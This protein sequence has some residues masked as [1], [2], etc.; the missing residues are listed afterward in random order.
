MAARRGATTVLTLTSW[1]NGDPNGLEHGYSEFIYE[2]G[3]AGVIDPQLRTGGVDRPVTS[4]EF[5]RSLRTD[6]VFGQ[7]DDGNDFLVSIGSYPDGGHT[8][9]PG[10]IAD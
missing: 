5:Q 6:E 2:L 10:Q 9:V 1:F 4:A 7:L 3:D 8:C